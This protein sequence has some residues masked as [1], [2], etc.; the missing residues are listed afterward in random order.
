MYILG[1]ESKID[2]VLRERGTPVPEAA[3]WSPHVRVCAIKCGEILDVGPDEARAILLHEKRATVNDQLKHHRYRM[4][5]ASQ[6]VEEL[7]KA[8]GIY[9]KKIAETRAGIEVVK[10][11]VADSKAKIEEF[12]LKLLELDDVDAKVEKALSDRPSQAGPGGAAGI[13]PPPAPLSSKPNG[14]QQAKR[15]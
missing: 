10:A 6:R 4:A 7:S 3:T 8:I 11:E 14:K 12:E 15:G 13:V 2:G 9:E 5:I 1:R